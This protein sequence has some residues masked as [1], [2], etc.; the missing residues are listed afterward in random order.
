MSPG[1]FDVHAFAA[2]GRLAIN[3]FHGACR[4]KLAVLLSLILFVCG[5]VAAQA[6]KGRVRPLYVFVS[7][8]HLGLGRTPGNANVWEPREDF[9]WRTAFEEFLE[10]ISNE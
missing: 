6:D 1:A 5:D 4:W 10:F 8:L 2:G 3:P 7:D 9:R